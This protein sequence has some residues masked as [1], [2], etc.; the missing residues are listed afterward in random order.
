MT[1]EI[2]I[3]EHG[4][5]KVKVREPQ[6]GGSNPLTLRPYQQK[7]IDAV[8]TKWNE[9]NRLLGVAPTGSGKTIKFA[10]IA[11]TRSQPGRVLI[12][13]HRDELI[14]QARDKLF[15]AC[16][17]LTSKEKANDYAD[18]DAGVVIG[19]VQTLSRNSRLSRFASDHFSTVIVDEAHRT[20][21][22]SYIRIL[23]HFACA[24]VLGVTATPDRGDRR[25]LGQYYEDIAFEISLLDLIKDGWLCPIR[26]KT[27]PL[28]I[29]ISKVGMRAGDYSERKLRR[30]LSRYCTSL[31]TRSACMSP[32][33][34]R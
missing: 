15:K 22:D 4:A 13:A 11:S 30:R 8:L 14:E 3:R 7:S 10:H 19:S 12:L 5:D 29:D 1:Q 24:K 27:I 32:S 33:A 21:A 34:R 6:K 28:Q 31:Q 26:I 2:Y 17:L 23:N 25:S 16:E 9:F 20:L 18:M